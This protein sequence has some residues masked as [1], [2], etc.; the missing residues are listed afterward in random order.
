MAASYLEV[1]LGLHEAN[2]AL[3][4][5]PHCFVAALVDRLD[6]LANIFA[7]KNPFPGSPDP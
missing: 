4:K 5:I 1:L 2:D 6:K 7:N 3:D